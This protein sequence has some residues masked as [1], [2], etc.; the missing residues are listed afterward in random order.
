MQKR[1]ETREGEREGFWE[2][3]EQEEEGVVEWTGGW[4]EL[5]TKLQSTVHVLID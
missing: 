2:E 4:A 1:E 5:P 3:E